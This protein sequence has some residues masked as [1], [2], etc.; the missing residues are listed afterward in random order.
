MDSLYQ[1]MNIQLTLLRHSF[2][3]DK[4]SNKE[5]SADFFAEL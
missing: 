4:I 1:A 2:N 5:I 3:G